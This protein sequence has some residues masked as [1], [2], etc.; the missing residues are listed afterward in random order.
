MAGLYYQKYM[1]TGFVEEVPGTDLAVL[2]P[3]AFKNKELIPLADKAIEYYKNQQFEL[4]RDTYKELI[5]QGEDEPTGHYGL[6][7]SLLFLDDADGAEQSFNRTLE[8]VPN[9]PGAFLGLGSV[10]SWRRDPEQSIV[11]Y[12]KA[13]AVKP[14]YVFAHE[15]VA[16]EYHHIGE[17]NLAIK[18]YKKVVELIPDT[19]SAKNSQRAIDKI[20]RDQENNKEFY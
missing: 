19:R 3:Y 10:A 13:L 7:V 9:D 2:K 6:G 12:K 1:E 11:F 5:R 14:N 15:F 20:T 4:A 17:Y 8:L 18:H 16:I